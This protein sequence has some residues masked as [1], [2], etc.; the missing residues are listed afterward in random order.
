MGRT[1][2]EIIGLLSDYEILCLVT[3]SSGLYDETQVS[4][5]LG[6]YSPFLR[7]LKPLLRHNLKY[8]LKLLSIRMGT[9]RVI[10]NLNRETKK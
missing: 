9:H 2:T 3:R 6:T 8:V 10:S 7:E 5:Y 4:R 1:H